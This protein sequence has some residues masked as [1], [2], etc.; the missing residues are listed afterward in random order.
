VNA[1]L[2]KQLNIRSKTAE[3]ELFFIS[4]MFAKQGAKFRGISDMILMEV[5][6]PFLA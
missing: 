4:T 5:K 1:C 3:A 6:E 2:C